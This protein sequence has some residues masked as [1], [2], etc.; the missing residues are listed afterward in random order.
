MSGELKEIGQRFGNRKPMKAKHLEDGQELNHLA[1][2]PVWT[3]KSTRNKYHHHGYG[4]PNADTNVGRRGLDLQLTADDGSTVGAE[5]VARPV[6][7]TDESFDTRKAVGETV[8]LDNLRDQAALNMRDRELFPA[9]KPGAAQDEFIAWEV[10]VDE[11]QSGYT[12]DA[13]ASDGT[14]HYTE[15]RFDRS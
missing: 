8:D 3:Q 14:I 5:G 1:F 7:Y 2:I 11:T 10:Q 12:V 13:S 9:A 4:I 15:R 6:V